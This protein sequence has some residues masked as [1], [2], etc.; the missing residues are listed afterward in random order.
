[1]RRS[2]NH[3][4][5]PIS[6]TLGRPMERGSIDWFVGL[7]VHKNSVVATAL[8]S[9]GRA[10]HR[11]KFGSS[12]RELT[13]YLRSLPGSKLV[14]LESCGFWEH[15]LDAVEASG[16][17]VVLSNPYRTR[18]IAEAS[19]KTDRVDSEALATLLRLNSLP[20]VYAPPPETRELRHLIQERI[21]YRRKAKGIMHRT[22]FA[23]LR[24][25]IPYEDRI[26]VHRRKRET[27]RT[28]HLS[29]V[30]RALDALTSI[31]DTC[32]ELDD[33]IEEAWTSSREAQLL[34]SIPGIGKLTAVALVAYLCPIERFSSAARLASYVG[35]SPTTH[36][37]G[38]SIYHGKL[39]KDSNGTLR[40]LLIEAAWNHRRLCARSDVSQI[41][42]RL[43][44]R[45]G[46]SKANVAAAHKLVRVIYA[47]LKR[48]ETFRTHAPGPTT[49]MQS[50]RRPRMTAVQF[51]R[52]AA[53]GPSTADSPWA[54]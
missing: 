9:G 48:K 32:R 40:W 51:V 31:E 27:L 45:R 11:S 23:L 37:S 6:S 46:I 21:F 52:R 13:D 19:L 22:Y 54:P 30:D 49:S 41:A 50:L 29:E 42:K 34:T 35:L 18:L 10:T 15:Y 14:T 39:K 44:R 33:A 25:G 8:D 28:L 5:R 2:K 36:Q 3:G 43:T 1:M 16:A 4:G 53:L 47:M 7:D 26:L 20:T 24:R 12:D 17:S 38:D